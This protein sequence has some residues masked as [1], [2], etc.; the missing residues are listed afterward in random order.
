MIPFMKNTGCPIITL[1]LSFAN[2]R[3]L[4]LIKQN[5]PQRKALV[6]NYK[7][8]VNADLGEK[9]KATGYYLRARDEVKKTKDYRLNF[10]I[11]AN[12]GMDSAM[13]AIQEAY[14]AVILR[15]R[16]C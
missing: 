7:G 9:E 12:L 4:R 5:N 11:H 6:L 3:S 16:N 2:Q 13:S 1:L 8:R 10:L 15:Q 14:L